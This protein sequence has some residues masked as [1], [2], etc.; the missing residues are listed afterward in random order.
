[1]LELT[2]WA[3]ELIESVEVEDAIK[4]ADRLYWNITIV[5][6]ESTYLS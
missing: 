4:L 1:M 2:K 3:A 5:G 6:N